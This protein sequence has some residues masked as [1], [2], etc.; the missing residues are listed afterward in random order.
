[1]ICRR[2]FNARSVASSA[3]KQPSPCATGNRNNVPSPQPCVKRESATS[4]RVVTMSQTKCKDLF[5]T[6]AP[7]GKPSDSTAAEII[8]VGK[9]ARQHDRIETVHGRFLVPNIIRAQSRDAVQGRETILIAI[10]SWK[11]NDREFHRHE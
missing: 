10:R 6:N 1:M 2:S 7:G 8:A 4:T 3:K 9:S 5:R 11:L